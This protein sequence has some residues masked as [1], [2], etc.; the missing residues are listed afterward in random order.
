MNIGR[1]TPADDAIL[2]DHY[3]ALWASYGTPSDAFLPD[4]RANVYAFLSE[5]RERRRLAAFIATVDGE[6]AGSSGCQL[7]PD[8]YPAVVRPTYRLSGYIWQVYVDPKFRRR[9]AGRALTLAAVDELQRLGCQ[10]V[11]LHYS[12]DGKPL[13]Q[14]MG[15]G[16]SNE[17]R[18]RL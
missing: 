12:E 14:A 6:V 3:L 7:R 15:F 8:L 18:L 9:G 4:A 13:Y 10:T 5:G 2:I 1:A 17:L 11:I 16:E